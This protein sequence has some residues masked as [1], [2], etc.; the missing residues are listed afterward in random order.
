MQEHD[1]A[2]GWAVGQDDMISPAVDLTG[3][4]RVATVGSSRLCGREQDK[5][6]AETVHGFH[7]MML[8]ER[9]PP[10]KGVQLTAA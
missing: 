9:M 1:R 3:A 4:G 7:G 8:P 10:A 2:L 6:G 5:G